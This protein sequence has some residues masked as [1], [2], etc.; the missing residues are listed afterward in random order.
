MLKRFGVGVA[1]GLVA[2][3]A[4]SAIS[5][6]GDVSASNETTWIG[7][8]VKPLS[9]DLRK[10]WS[11][12]GA[13]MMVT[14]VDEGSPAERAGITRGDVLVVLGSVSLRSTADFEEAQSRVHPGEPV[15]VVIARD[16]GRMV[17]IVNLDVD[18][19][20]PPTPPAVQ[21]EG[22]AQPEPQADPQLE[23]KATPA[24]APVTAAVAVAPQPKPAWGGRCE[25]LSKEMATALGVSVESGVVVLAVAS[26]SP[27]DQA[28]IRAGDVIS[29]IGGQSVASSD[30]VEKA[31]SD[32]SSSILVRDHRK[33][34][35]QNVE[36]RFG[37]AATAA[38]PATPEQLQKDADRDREIEEL[39]DT[40]RSLRMEVRRLRT[41]L[42]GIRSDSQ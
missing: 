6:G 38:G 37:T 24:E 39:R 22:P 7:V 31:F 41:E 10:Q 15:S 12:R 26:G 27:A 33:D 2:L 8:S 23:V 18:A 40:V 28:G 42:Q 19:P 3:S 20:P 16:Q 35:E 13:G 17:H 9:S 21:P 25:T 30:D 32:A 1:T 5:Q 29:D 14:A 34:Q 36:V 4:L 11:Y